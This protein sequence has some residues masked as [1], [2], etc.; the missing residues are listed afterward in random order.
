MP[1]ATPSRPTLLASLRHLPNFLGYVFRRFP[2]A[3]LT[4]VL[5]LAVLTFEYAVLSLMIPLSARSNGES[6]GG[7]VF[8]FWSWAAQQLHLKPVQMTWLWLFLM[9]LAVRTILGFAHMLSTNWLSKQVHRHLS[10]RAFQRVLVDEPMPQIYRRSIGYYITLAGDDTFRAGTIV[11]TAS[12]ALATLM[13]AAAG[14]GLLY[15]FS[16]S[17]FWATVAFLGLSALLVAVGF[18]TLMRV[19]A[20]S[21]VLARE[22]STAYI[23]ALNGLR[24]IRSM[25]SEP[26]FLNSYA[27]QISRYVRLLFEVDAVKSSIKFMPAIFALLV[28]VGLLWP[29]TEHA[30]S[31]TASFFFAITVLLIRVFAA[32]GSAVNLASVMLMDLRAAT[33][34]DELINAAPPHEEAHASSSEPLSVGDVELRQVE[35]GYRPGKKVLDGLDFTFRPGQTVAIV[36]P[37]GSGK[38]TLADM[39]L[40]LIRPDRGSILVNGGHGSLSALRQHVILVEQQARI[41]STSVRE[42]LLLGQKRDDKV[43]WEALRL[44][45]LDRHVRALPDGLS[46]P[47]EYQGANLSGGQRQRVGI[48]R[49][50]IR[51]PKVLILDEATS[52]LDARTRGLVVV[53]LRDFMRD[54]ILIF[55]THDDALADVADVVLHLG[56]PVIDASSAAHL[57]PAS[58]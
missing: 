54:G 45:D 37:S 17:A 22:A 1:Y 25:A 52:A 40:G 58:A 34:I 31:V 9:L 55:I 33:D 23:E 47:F 16:A 14:F 24:S 42:N 3:R 11:N 41:F 38:S 7:T 32:L 26:F 6:G 19:N 39:L 18:R 2:L 49:A 20:R 15:V 28:G 29:G 46:A 27:N 12:Q 5:A 57:E 8:Q 30:E 56:H 4:L 48:A 36:G 51:E 21:V 35:Y 10:E 43:L 53:N 50:L 44:V 13:S